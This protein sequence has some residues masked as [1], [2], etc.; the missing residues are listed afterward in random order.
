M[1]NENRCDFFHNLYISKM[2]ILYRMMILYVSFSRTA[3][4][5][6]SAANW[7]S[8]RIKIHIFRFYQVLSW[9]VGKYCEPLVSFAS[10]YVLIG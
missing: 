1:S 7:Q 8:V 5:T 2:H 4:R 10:D 9:V 3:L 6:W